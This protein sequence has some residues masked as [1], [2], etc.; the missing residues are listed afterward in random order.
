MT[1]TTFRSGGSGESIRFAVGKCSLGSILVAATEQGVCV[2]LLP[3]IA[4]CAM[5]VR[6]PATDG[7]WRASDSL[8]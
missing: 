3:A 8:R 7:A 6:F 5:T 4:S 2:I 1:P